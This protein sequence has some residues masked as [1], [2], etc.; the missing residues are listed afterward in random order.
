MLFSWRAE[1]LHKT[2]HGC[3]ARNEYVTSG[4]LGRKVGGPIARRSRE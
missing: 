1:T 4:D 2:G 3:E